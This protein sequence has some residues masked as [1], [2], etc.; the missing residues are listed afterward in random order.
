MVK[1]AVAKMSSILWHAFNVI[2]FVAWIACMVEWVARGC[3]IPRWVHIFAGC[4]LAAG[5]VTAVVLGVC[6]MLTFTLAA[7]CILIPP[8]AAYFG[9]LWMFGPDHATR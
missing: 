2:I 9:W 3:P 7:S 6:G 4:L 8:V 5:I 1:G